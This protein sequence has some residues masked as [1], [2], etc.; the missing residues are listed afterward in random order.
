MLPLGWVA[1]GLFT[2]GCLTFYFYGKGASRRARK[3][4]EAE[5]NAD[6]VT[7]DA[8]TEIGG[9]IESAGGRRGRGANARWSRGH[10]R[11]GPGEASWCRDGAGDSGGELV[12]RRDSSREREQLR[13]GGGRGGGQAV[14]P[15][16]NFS[17]R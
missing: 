4:L 3:V 2:A 7:A 12:G 13:R 11:A 1:I 17:G 8:V 5:S 10:D 6:M 16:V 9:A 15:H 14:G